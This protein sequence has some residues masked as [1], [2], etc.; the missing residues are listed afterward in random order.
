MEFGTAFFVFI[1]STTKYFTGPLLAR[2]ASFGFWEIMIYCGSGGLSGVFIYSFLSDQVILL[3]EKL[4]YKLMNREKKASKV[5]SRKTR[6]MVKIK[7]KGGLW[8]IAFLTP[9]LLSMPVGVFLTMRYFTLKQSL[10]AQ[11]VAVVFWTVFFSFGYTYV[12]ELFG[13]E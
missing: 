10:F 11:C 4:V 8:A 12:G 3:Y 1:F 7:Q 13:F 5:F 9:V 6:M 2:T